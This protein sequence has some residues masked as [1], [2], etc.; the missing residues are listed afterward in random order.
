[1]R[2]IYRKGCCC[3]SFCQAEIWFRALILV[4]QIIQMISRRSTWNAIFC[5]FIRGSR[6]RLPRFIR[7]GA[8]YRR[9]CLAVSGHRSR[10][11]VSGETAWFAGQHHRQDQV[12]LGGHRTKAESLENADGLA[13][14]EP[15][16]R[17]EG[18][19]TGAHSGG[20][21]T[22]GRKILPRNGDLSFVH[23]WSQYAADL[24]PPPILPHPH[25]HPSS[26]HTLTGGLADCDG[27]AQLEL[28]LPFR[29]LR[30]KAD[31]STK[32]KMLTC[33][34]CPASAPNHQ[35]KLQYTYGLYIACSTGYV[36]CVYEKMYDR[37]FSPDECLTGSFLEK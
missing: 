32:K 24:R 37:S 2:G 23:L 31:M 11:G 12:Q 17:L 20:V 27:K 28:H 19:G 26:T 8:G 6:H 36:C 30:C 34:T 15:W 5:F 3:K 13:E 33:L 22:F 14:A 35:T 29:G 1:M 25:P 21:E 4:H 9:T 7:R 16:P 18:P 10:L